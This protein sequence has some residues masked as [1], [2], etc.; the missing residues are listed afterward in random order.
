MSIYFGDVVWISGPSKCGHNPDLSPHLAT[1]GSSGIQ[2]TNA[3]LRSLVRLLPVPQIPFSRNNGDD[4]HSS[5][6]HL[7][8]VSPCSL[9]QQAK[10]N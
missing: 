4:N 3:G 5:P 2:V 1:L 9:V 10:N 7:L 8:H 6:A